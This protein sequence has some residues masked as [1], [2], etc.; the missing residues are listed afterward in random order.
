M[1]YNI[2]TRINNKRSMRRTYQ[3]LFLVG[4]FFSSDFASISSVVCGA[5]SV[6]VSEVREKDV[7]VEAVT[8]NEEVEVLVVVKVW[9]NS[10]VDTVVGVN[11]VVF[12]LESDVLMIEV[13][14]ESAPAVLALVASTS[15][16]VD[17]T[18][19]VST[20]VT[21]CVV[22]IAPV[23][24]TRAFLAWRRSNFSAVT[25]STVTLLAFAD[26]TK[27]TISVSRTWPGNRGPGL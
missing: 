8:V 16:V 27:F 20:V 9:P 21:T 10:L 26:P 6:A 18:G 14:E 11:A 12:L 4:T 5:L 24:V 13:V 15:G 7:A 1:T 3:Y 17:A 2:P 23:A 25:V 22:A 19:L